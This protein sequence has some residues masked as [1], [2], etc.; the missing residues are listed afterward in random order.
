MSPLPVTWKDI[1]EHFDNAGSLSVHHRTQK[2]NSY[3]LRIPSYDRRLLERFR[4]FLGRGSI[5]EETKRR[6][7]YYR[8]EVGGLGGTCEVLTRMLPYLGKK[9]QAARQWLKQFEPFVDFTL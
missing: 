8:L 2:G 6:G 1:S 7:P 3:R 5:S 9:R 4:R